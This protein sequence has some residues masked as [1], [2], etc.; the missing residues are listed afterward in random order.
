MIAHGA[1]AWSEHERRRWLRP[2]W[3]R[4]VRPDI[5]RWLT[6]E[7][8]RPLRPE[9]GQGE[10]AHI[11]HDGV[12][13]PAFVLALQNYRKGLE[14]LRDQLA[15][16]KVE[17]K[18]R[19][20]F[21][22]LKYGFNPA[23]PRVPAGNPDGGQW[24]SDSSG[25]RNDPRVLSDATPDNEA[26]PGAQYAQNRSGRGSGRITI[27]GQE[28]DATPGQAA[29]AAVAEPERKTRFG[30]CG[31]LIRIGTQARV[32][33]GRASKVKFEKQT[34]WRTKPRRGQANSRG[35][36]SARDRLRVSRYRREDQNATLRPRSGVRSIVS[37]RR[38]D[39]IP[40]AL[41]TPALVQATSSSIINC[42]AS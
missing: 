35:S 10:D 16:L 42:P 17:L 6:P 14:R 30:G 28:F 26:K 36:G 38:P 27:G 40:V 2:D 21:D 25:G 24:M 1:A 33:T 41:R 13:D 12:D 3:K 18:F 31:S 37:D 39:A 7:A 34:I 22:Q 20:F 15:D 4:Y 29:R 32:S 9:L 19:R 23:Q 8:K 11:D 5:D